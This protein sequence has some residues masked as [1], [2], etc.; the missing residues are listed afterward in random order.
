VELEVGVETNPPDG[1][2]RNA[3]KAARASGDLVPLDKND[4]NCVVE[5]QGSHGQV[6]AVEPQG[7]NPD[8]QGHQA[9]RHRH[10]EHGGPRR[11][12]IGGRE[13]GGAIG[14]QAEKGRMSQGNLAGIPGEQVQAQNHDDE[15][16]D[17]VQET[18]GKGVLKHQRSQEQEDGQADHRD[19]GMVPESK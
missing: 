9:H 10:Q 13:N 1:K 19:A 15:K 4:M 16:A 12:L 8:Y 11:P 17:I 2:G 18:Q 6:V 14:P 3:R 7:G 5:P